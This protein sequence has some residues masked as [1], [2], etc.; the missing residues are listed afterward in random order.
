[1]DV[2][3]QI[4]E[5]FL[6]DVID[7]LLSTED[8]ARYIG[9]SKHTLLHWRHIHCGPDHIELSPCNLKYRVA[10]LE[11]WLEARKVRNS[12]NDETAMRAVANEKEK[13][14]AAAKLAEK[15]GATQQR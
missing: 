13:T 6:V 9:V 3:S 8:A 1:M 2:H 4:Y 10:D 15:A 11:S 14:R 5:E 7:R 12:A